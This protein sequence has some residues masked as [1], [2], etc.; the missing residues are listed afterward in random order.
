MLPLP[1]PMAEWRLEITRPLCAHRDGC[2]DL[3]ISLGR[4]ELDCR[5]CISYRRDPD[6]DAEL[7]DARRVP[8]IRCKE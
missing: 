7:V 4:D 6:L 1:D 8:D 3:A 5:P 2:L